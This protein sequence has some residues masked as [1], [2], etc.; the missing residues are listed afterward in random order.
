MN[1]IDLLNY[2]EH[3]KAA[4]DAARVYPVG[5]PRRVLLETTMNELVSKPLPPVTKNKNDDN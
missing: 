3:Y 5:D 4:K 1:E 2:W